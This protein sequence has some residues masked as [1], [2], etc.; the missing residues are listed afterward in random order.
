MELGANLGYITGGPQDPPSSATHVALIYCTLGTLLQQ[1]R[2]LGPAEVAERYRFICVDEI[3]E[4]SLDAD[5]ALFLLR[6]LLRYMLE[7]RAASAPFLVLMSATIDSV[8]QPSGP[9]VFCAMTTAPI[10][11]TTSTNSMRRIVFF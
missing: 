2:T 10:N 8:S 9:S 7:I 5:L 6:R 11:S 3:H 1:L 4:R